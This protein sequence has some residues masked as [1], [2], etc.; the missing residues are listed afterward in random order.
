MYIIFFYYLDIL[1]DILMFWMHNDDLFAGLLFQGAKR[2]CAQLK[3]KGPGVDEFQQQL[4]ST[5]EKW[6][7]ERVE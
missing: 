2:W 5:A 6:E 1:D 3:P 7:R 4:G